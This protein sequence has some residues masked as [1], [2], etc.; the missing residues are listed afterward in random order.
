MRKKI[1]NLR[2]V[3]VMDE[4]V[5]CFGYCVDCGSKVTDKNAEEYYC[6]DDGLV[7]CDIDCVLSYYEINKIEV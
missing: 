2:K 1:L 5:R 4:E 3:R 6:T 7:F